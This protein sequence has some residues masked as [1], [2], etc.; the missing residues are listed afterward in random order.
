MKAPYMQEAWFT[1]LQQANERMTRS[2]IAAS[3][4]LSLP[5]VSQIFNASGLYG[6]GA[7]S[8]TRIA[9]KVLRVFGRFECP[10]LTQQRGEVV[11]IDCTTCRGYAH[12]EPPIGSP[13]DLMHWQACRRCEHAPHTAPPQFSAHLPRGKRKPKADTTATTSATTHESTP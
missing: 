2:R 4:G 11:L 5:A 6:T 8:T 13:Q 9:E 1:L 7:A 10:H 12:R 3:L